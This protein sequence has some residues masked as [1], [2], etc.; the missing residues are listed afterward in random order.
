MKHL[1]VNNVGILYF[2][3]ASM[4][5]LGG[6]P[7]KAIELLNKFANVFI[8]DFFPF[9]LRGDNFFDKLDNF[10]AENVTPVPRSE[11]ATK[12]DMA[13]YPNNPI[14]DSLRENPDFKRIV[15]RMSDFA[16]GA[17]NG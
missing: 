1:N 10:I 6:I 17:A 4:Y 3:G 13:Q 9:E 5:Q 15:K 12:K 8:N 16:G 14:F 7:E 2:L 11:E